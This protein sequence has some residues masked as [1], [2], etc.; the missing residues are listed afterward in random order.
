[1]AGKKTPKF[2]DKE[3]EKLLVYVRSKPYLYD[4]S[5]SKHMDRSLL[6]NTW[7]KIANDLN[8]K[9]KGKQLKLTGNLIFSYLESRILN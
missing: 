1:M 6:K 2:S 4:S 8:K 5:H 9:R 3:T 7:D